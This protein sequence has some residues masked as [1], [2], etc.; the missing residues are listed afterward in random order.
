MDGVGLG[1]VHLEG[2]EGLE[3][4]KGFLVSLASADD[5]ELAR[6]ADLLALGQEAGLSRHEGGGDGQHHLAGGVAGVGG[7]VGNLV[8]VRHAV[9]E[10]GGGVEGGEG[11]EDFGGDV[12]HCIYHTAA[13]VPIVQIK[14]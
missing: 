3:G 4:L 14:D 1:E 5:S 9:E 11:V 10:A 12:V 2:L 13:L 7:V 6:R 8:V